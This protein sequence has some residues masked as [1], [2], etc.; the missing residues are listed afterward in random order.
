MTGKKKKFFSLEKVLPEAASYCVLFLSLFINRFWMLGDI[1][2]SL[3]RGVPNFYSWIVLWNCRVLET[4]GFSGYWAGNTMLPYHNAL[5][6]SENMIGLTPF[7]IPLRII[8]DNPVLFTNLLSLFMVMFTMI[9]LFQVLKKLSGSRIGAVVGTLIFTL[10]PWSMKEF[11]LGRFHMLAVF[12]IPLIFYFNIKFWKDNNRKNL[13]FLFLFFLWTFL[14]N[15]YIGIFFTLFLGLF[16]LIWYFYEKKL[17]SIKKILEWAVSVFLVWVFLLPVFLKYRNTGSDLGMIRTLND[18]V[19]YTGPLNSWITVPDENFIYG[20]ILNIFPKGSKDGI[21]ENYMFPGIVASLF[22][23]LSFFYSKFPKWLKSLRLTGLAMAL[24]AIGPFIPGISVKIP[25]P[26]SFFWYLFP[27]LQ[28]TRNPHRFA[29]FA[30]FS[31]AVLAAFM[32]KGLLKKRKRNIIYIFLIL[33]L[34]L[35]ETQTVEKSSVAIERYSKQFYKQLNKETNDHIVVELPFEIHSDLRAMAAS[36]FFWHKTI[37][38]ISGLRPPLQSQMEKELRNF[39]SRLTIKLLQSLKIDRIV[40]NERFYLGKRIRFLKK[41]RKFPQINFLF[42]KGMKSAWSLKRGKYYKNL[43]LKKDFFIIT[44]KNH[45]KKECKLL[46]KVRNAGESILFNPKAP[47]KFK[48]TLSKEWELTVFS[49]KNGKKKILKKL[50]WN[51]PALFHENNSL[52]EIMFNYS[53][54]VGDICLQIDIP[55]ETVILTSVKGMNEY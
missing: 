23:F 3:F 18:Q 44:K 54:T 9:I 40:I 29:I 2:Y 46:L 39:P 52:K 20:K 50:I 33:I 55:G 51:P 21:V 49:K 38:G 37:N 48:F 16:N 24:L 35:I 45:E 27:P 6:F 12:F 17:F 42:M 25:L 31:I 43:D 36:T 14:S 4:F 10:Y 7:A 5:A 32:I 53:G 26:F 15:I 41:I 8:T 34:I 47:S 22:F 19:N 1:G 28:A 13:F 11:S 30:V